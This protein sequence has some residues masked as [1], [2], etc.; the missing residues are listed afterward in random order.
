[1]AHR[2][3]G[4]SDIFEHDVIIRENCYAKNFYGNWL[5]P[6]ASSNP[7][8][9]TNGALLLNTSD[10]TL[11]LYY[12]GSWR[13]LHTFTLTNEFVLLENGD[14]LLLENGDKIIL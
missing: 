6:T 9:G 2:A 12:A 11:Y 3:E 7:A 14:F 4:L 5:I 10:H 8:T 1:M 13:A